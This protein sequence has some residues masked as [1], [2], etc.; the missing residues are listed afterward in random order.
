MATYSTGV[1]FTFDSTVYGEVAD[2]S[3]SWGGGYTEGRAVSY[4]HEA[5][6]VSLTAWAAIATT[7]WAKAGLLTITGGG[8]N[9]T[10]LAVCTEVAA[11]AQ[12]N[13]VTRYS[14]TFTLIG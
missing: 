10:A 14:A 3:W 1:T 9:L 13:G 12:L 5:G 8:M 4:R 2:L 6:T 7:Q 11:E